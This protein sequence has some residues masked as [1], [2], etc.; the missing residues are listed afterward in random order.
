MTK[1]TMIAAWGGMALLAFALGLAS[2][3]YVLPNPPSVPPDVAL[4]LFRHPLLAIHAVTAASALILGPFQFLRRKD[5][6]RGRTHRVIGTIYVALCLASAPAGL[7][8]AFGSS[9]GPVATGG[10]GLLAIVWFFCTA[11]GLRM[12][13][14][15][16]YAEH[17]RWMIC[18]YA[19]TF[20]AVLLRLYLPIPPMLGFSFVDG[21]R[22]ISW[23]CWVPTLL[24]VEMTLRLTTSVRGA[25]L[26]RS[27]G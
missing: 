26:A 8:L 15:G 20:T 2:L 24:L 25:G 1:V 18:S 21:Y 11:Q 27:G 5:G 22:A 10:F 4:N 23:L 17:R 7:V 3:R 14:T 13:L 6:R 19:L 9:A 16:R 12:V